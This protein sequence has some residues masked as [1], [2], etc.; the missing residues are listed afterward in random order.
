VFQNLAANAPHMSIL[1]G[2]CIYHRSVGIFLISI[3]DI[4]IEVSLLG[5]GKKCHFVPKV[6]IPYFATTPY[7]KNPVFVGR[8]GI[9][10][11]IRYV[12]APTDDRISNM[13][14]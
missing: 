10:N 8:C 6:V 3:E 7:E 9:L 12:L 14:F 11:D 4:H 5:L 2:L 1:S 13:H